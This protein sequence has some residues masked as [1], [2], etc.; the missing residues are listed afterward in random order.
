MD[1]K[2][3]Q[4]KLFVPL[5]KVFA[6]NF[7]SWALFEKYV[8]AQV[9]YICLIKSGKSMILTSFSCSLGPLRDKCYIT[10]FSSMRSYLGKFTSNSDFQNMLL[11]LSP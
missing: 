8:T 5:A 10:S 6:F 1:Y 4:E 3:Q 11:N 2:T 9:D 7:T